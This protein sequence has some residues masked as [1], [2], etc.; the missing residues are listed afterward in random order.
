M[1]I[2]RAVPEDRYAGLAEPE[3]IATALPELDLDD[4]VEPDAEAL[5]ELAGA[6]EEAALAHPKITNSEGAEAEL[7]AQPHDARG[8]Q[9]LRRL[10]RALEPW[11][12]APP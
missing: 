5:A 6:A 1:T 9:R 4:G 7:V 3:Q 2:A 11:P 12:R 8:D 10:D